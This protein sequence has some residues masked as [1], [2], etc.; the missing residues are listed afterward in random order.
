MSV[1]QELI[2]RALECA[3]ADDPKLNEPLLFGA[4]RQATNHG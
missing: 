3:A 1:E 4:R 2:E